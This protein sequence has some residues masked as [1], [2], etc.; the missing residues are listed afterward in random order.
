MILC[1]RF[2]VDLGRSS[3]AQQA[4][5]EAVGGLLSIEMTFD[6]VGEMFERIAQFRRALE[7][8][9]RNTV[10]YAEQGERGLASR[11]RD[12]AARMEA[13]LAANPDRYAAPTIPGAIERVLPP[14]SEGQLAPQRQ[15]RR[16][17][18]AKPL[19]KRPYDPSYEFRKR[20]RADYL[21]LISPSPERVRQFLARIVLPSPHCRGPIRR[22]PDRRRFSGLRRSP[23]LRSDPGES[24]ACL[25]RIQTRLSA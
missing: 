14:W 2:L 6:T 18:E 5:D 1:P 23:T 20:M 8:R 24:V 15:A 3:D 10:K 19:G 22:T 16:P 4:R 12:L 7:T 9:L 13:L 25:P 11:A 17:I 21:D